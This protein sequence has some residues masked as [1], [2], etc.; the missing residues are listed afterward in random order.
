MCFLSSVPVVILVF[1]LLVPDCWYVKY[2]NGMSNIFF[3]FFCID[4]I[5]GIN[6]HPSEFIFCQYAPA[7]TLLSVCSCPYSSVVRFCPYS[8]VST[9]LSLLFCQYA[10]PPTLLSLHSCPYSS[11]RTF[12]SLLFCQYASAP[13]LLS[14]RS[15]P[16]SS[17]STLLPLLFCQYAPAPTLLHGQHL[18]HGLMRTYC[19]DSHGLASHKIIS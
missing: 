5:V 13:T 1:S 11:V 17:V 7:P 19:I 10:P 2:K 6:F 15:C 12:L 4:W 8:S 18:C 14:V 9:L 3:Q 16:Y